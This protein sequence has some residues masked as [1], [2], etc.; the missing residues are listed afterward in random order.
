[1]QRHRGMRYDGEFG[2]EMYA[3][4]EAGLEHKVH[5]RDYRRWS[6]KGRHTLDHEGPRVPC[7]VV[8]V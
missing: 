1:M 6:G 7:Y 2:G 5:M 8:Y 3:S 4:K